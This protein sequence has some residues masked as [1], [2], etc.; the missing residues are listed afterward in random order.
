M[1]SVRFIRSAHALLDF[2]YLAKYPI[3]TN[4]TLQLLMDAL[5]RFHANRDIFINLGIRSQFNLPK[6]HYMSHYVELIKYFGTTDNFDTQYTERLH[7][8][9]PKHSYAAT[10][11][12][13]KYEQMTSW[14]DRKERVLR[15]EQYI[16]WRRAGNCA[17]T[18]VD[19]E[20]PSLDM[21]WE[22]SMTKHPSLTAVPLS[23]LQDSYGA[24]LFKVAL[25]RFIST[26][27]DRNQSRQQLERSL[28]RIRLPFTRLPVWH[29]IK[30]TRSDPLTGTRSTA[31]SI[32][33]QPARHDKR[34]RPIPG[35]FDTALI[36]DG[37]GVEY[38]IK[39]ESECYYS[40]ATHSDPQ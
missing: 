6:L 8:E 23:R 38:G 28:W 5:S 1:S 35:R 40:S 31:D 22:L 16:E 33:V 37:T 7:I 27:N 4:L 3:H 15:H 21:R 2:L 11:H 12:K 10:N 9:I 17:P 30:F 14:S 19:R 20:P 39:G 34:Q 29:V 32:H 24:P 13:D 36:N 25:R 18:H 26:T